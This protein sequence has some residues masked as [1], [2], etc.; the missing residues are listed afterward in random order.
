MSASE[1]AA[2]LAGGTATRP[3]IWIATDG[4][5]QAGQEVAFS[6]SGGSNDGDTVPVPNSEGVVVLVFHIEFGVELGGASW[7]FGDGASGSGASIAH[8]FQSAGVY[9]VAVSAGDA[10][11]VTECVLDDSVWACADVSD[12]VDLIA[13]TTTIQVT[14][15]EAPAT[16]DTPETPTPTPTPT[17]T[18][19]PTPTPTPT[20]TPQTDTVQVVASAPTL[21]INISP[22]RG[23]AGCPEASAVHPPGE[24]KG[25]P[26]PPFVRASWTSAVRAPGQSSASA[27]GPCA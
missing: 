11:S 18:A 26:S 9:H 4:A 14:I 6:V 7:T 17:P 16:P 21:T 27:S 20:A 23:L 3:V 13:A 24:G 15:A 22:A 2:A 19:T 5:L 10:T 12:P 1:S 8:T 25:E